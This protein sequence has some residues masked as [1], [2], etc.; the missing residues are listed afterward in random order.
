[1]L[2]SIQKYFVA[3]AV[4]AVSML[5][6]PLGSFAANYYNVVD[7]AENMPKALQDLKLDF[8][9]VVFDAATKKAI[10]STTKS[11]EVGL[12]IKNNS[13]VQFIGQFSFPK[14]V[15]SN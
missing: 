14:V 4:C 5:S 1:M 15:I 9:V 10:T 3:M 6:V 13:F 8:D 11:I 12:E 7:V 2:T